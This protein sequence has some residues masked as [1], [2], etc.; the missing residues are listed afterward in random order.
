MWRRQALPNLIFAVLCAVE[1]TGSQAVAAPARVEGNPALLRRIDAIVEEGR[2]QLDLPGVSLAIMRGDHLIVAKGYGWADRDARIPAGP[3]TVYPIGSL[4]KQMTAAAVMTLAGRGQV[5]LDEP[6]STYLPEYRPPDGSQPTVR[7]LLQQTSGIPTWDDLPELQDESDLGKFTLPNVVAVLAKHPAAY[8][9][10]YWWSYSNSNYTLLARMIERVSGM[11]YD[12]FLEQSLFAPLK[13]KSTSECQ[14]RPGWPGGGNLARGYEHVDGKFRPR[15]M[16]AAT[17]IAMAGAGGICSDALDLARW[18]RMLVSGRAIG[19]PAYR[20]MTRPTKVRA[21]FTAPYGFGVSLLPFAG[22][23]AVW[24]T[25]VMA[26]YIAVLVYLPDPDITIAALTNSRHAWLH[27]VVKDVARAVIGIKPKAARDLPI[28]DAEI[29]RSVGAYDDYMFKFRVYR[30]GQ[31]L[32]ANIDQL[33]SPLRLRYQ[34]GHD[35]ATGEPEGFLFHFAP[36]TGAVKRV[37]WE[38]T[39]L[40]AFARPV[41]H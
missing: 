5:R 9:A 25:G 10:G 24:H 21:G 37:D 32:F 2:R 28:P 33:G 18:T 41:K 4:S 23:R 14:S 36:T 40:R 35:Y 38:W 1:L 39:E 12:R 19:L 29:E 27:S 26:G 22:Q 15:P 34:G 30:E 16:R 7:Q 17:A 11:S 8:P 20:E 31:Q 3:S 6:I 13:L